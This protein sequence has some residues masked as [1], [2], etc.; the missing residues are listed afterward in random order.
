MLPRENVNFRLNIRNARFWHSGRSFALGGESKNDG[1][2]NENSKKAGEV[3]DRST[4]WKRS[5][6]I[7]SYLCYG[8]CPRYCTALAVT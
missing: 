3:K 6:A 7:T 5:F 4:Q 8:E 2:G 1:N